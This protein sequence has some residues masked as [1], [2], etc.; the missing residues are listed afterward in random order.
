MQESTTIDVIDFETIFWP[1]RLA[2]R[3]EAEK[4]AEHA[5]RIESQT[6]AQFGRAW[7]PELRDAPARGGR[8]EAVDLLCLELGRLTTWLTRVPRGPECELDLLVD[9]TATTPRSGNSAGSS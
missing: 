1:S 2:Y 5:L 8:S 7:V 4:N 3:S 9:Y 6:P